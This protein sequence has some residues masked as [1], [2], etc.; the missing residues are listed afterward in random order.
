MD[1]AELVITQ[2]CDIYLIA[3]Y[4]S[5][6]DG[7]GVYQLHFTSDILNDEN[8]ITRYYGSW[9]IATIGV[10]DG[11]LDIVQQHQCGAIYFGTRYWVK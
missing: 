7:S 10:K 6:E 4:I 2:S 8:I 5:D 11:R 3:Q 9:L 1:T